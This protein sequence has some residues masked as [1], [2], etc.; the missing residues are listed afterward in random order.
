MMLT[1]IDN[2]TSPLDCWHVRNLAS[3]IFPSG[4]ALLWPRLLLASGATWQAPAGRG[5][6]QIGA[7]E[8]AWTLV[9]GARALELSTLDQQSRS[10][11][12]KVPHAQPKKLAKKL[13][14]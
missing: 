13:C 8:R 6:A 9:W 14:T 12:A 1:M 11:I 10:R 5:R 4:P 3:H 7:R 2:D